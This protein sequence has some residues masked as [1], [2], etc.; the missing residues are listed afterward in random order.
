M[1]NRD[2]HNQALFARLFVFSANC[3]ATSTTG[4]W[5]GKVAII[6]RCPPIAATVLAIVERRGFLRFSRREIYI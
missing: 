3:E 5:S 4:S 6:V 2:L 1:W